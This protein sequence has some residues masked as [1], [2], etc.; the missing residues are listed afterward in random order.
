MTVMDGR[1][2]ACRCVLSMFYNRNMVQVSSE[3]VSD[4]IRAA[5]AFARLGLSMRDPHYRERAIE[6]LAL[7]IVEKL[8]APM[9]LQDANQIPLP[10]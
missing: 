2:I 6:A 8:E 9:P 7:A 5:P 3:T 1:R 10:L 4:A